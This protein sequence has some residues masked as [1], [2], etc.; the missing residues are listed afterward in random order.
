MCRYKHNYQRDKNWLQ[1]SE[2]F[3]FTYYLFNQSQPIR[4]GPSH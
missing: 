2:R 4:Y 1:L 3:S